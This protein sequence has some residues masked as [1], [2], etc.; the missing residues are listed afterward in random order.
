MCLKLDDVTLGLRAMVRLLNLLIMLARGKG[1]AYI[2]AMILHLLVV[3]RDRR[4]DMPAWQIAS[5]GL[6]AYNE[7]AGELSFSV[8]GRACLGDTKRSDFDHLSKLYRLFNVYRSVEDEVGADVDSQRN[9]TS[10]RKIIK[11]DGPEVTATTEFVRAHLRQIRDGQLFVYNNTAKSFKDRAV[12][13]QHLKRIRHRELTLW[14]KQ[15]DMSSHFDGH[16]NKMEEL[17]RTD[18]GSAH[19][20]IWPELAQEAPAPVSEREVARY[21]L[22]DS[23]QEC[24]EDAVQVLP[25]QT[26]PKR[27]K[28]RTKAVV[29]DDDQQSLCSEKATSSD[30][31]Y[32]AARDQPSEKTAAVEPSSSKKGPE[33][34]GAWCNI[35][36]NAIISGGRRTRRGRGQRDPNSSDFPIVMGVRQSDIAD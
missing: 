4:L 10:W 5:H 29:S 11:N 23:D 25:A 13:I 8:L 24:I 27:K 3:F 16:I 31:E 19:S 21:D 15:E 28:S 17:L 1:H 26:Q 18:W 6:S 35:N 14:M 32:I 2:R 30:E 12:A 22:E 9:M 34:W 20:D 7:E 36:P 33:E